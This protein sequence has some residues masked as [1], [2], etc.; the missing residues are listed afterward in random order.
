MS[1]PSKAIIHLDALKHN[2]SVVQRLSGALICAVIKCDAYGHGALPVAKILQNKSVQ[3]FGV[4]CIEEAMELREAGITSPVLLMEGFFEPEEL[5]LADKYDFTLMLHQQEQINAL[6]AYKPKKAFSV[7]LKIDTGMHRL[8]FSSD[9][10]MNAYQSLKSCPHVKNDIVISTHFSSAEEPEK[11]YTRKQIALFN[12]LISNMNIK[13]SLSNSAAIMYPY[14]L[15][16]HWVRPGLMLYGVSPFV[17]QEVSCILKPV[18]EFKSHIIAIKKVPA[19]SS[20]GYN[21]TFVTKTE[22]LLGIVSVGYGDGYP[23]S[24]PTGTPVNVDKHRTRILG[25]VSMD[26]LCVDLSNIPNVRIGSEVTLWGADLPLEEV[27]SYTCQVP[28]A[29]LTGIKR[30]RRE[31]VGSRVMS[32]IKEMI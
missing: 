28:H 27:A 26:T 23:S 14:D 9:M 3:A 24:A 18:M 8:G 12:S 6:L 15:N 1:R 7:W 19:G 22:T 17:T 5:G 20:I 16:T 13:C 31:Y 11:D 30:I 32:E 10:F 2:V 21:N 29:L 25:K 4:A